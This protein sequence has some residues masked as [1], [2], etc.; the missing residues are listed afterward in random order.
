MGASS[1][2]PVVSSGSS[3]SLPTLSRMSR[4][5][6]RDTIRDKTNRECLQRA[7]HSARPALSSR[8][9]FRQPMNRA[10]LLTGITTQRPSNMTE[11]CKRSE[12]SAVTWRIA[13]RRP[14]FKTAGSFSVGGFARQDLR[15]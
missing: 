8:N 12:L 11:S 7:D 14:A 9:R 4:I 13:E 2:R 1:E 5:I 10:G 3:F 15:G 6:F